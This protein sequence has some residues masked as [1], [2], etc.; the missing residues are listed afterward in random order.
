MMNNPSEPVIALVDDD[1]IFQLTASRM[2]RSTHLTHTILQFSNGE[3]ALR[4]LSENADKK[5]NLPDILFLDIN[6][7]YVD[8]WM[9]LEDYVKLKK[10]L[11]KE[12]L[13]YM[14]SSSIDP[15]DINRAKNN[16]SVKDYLIKPIS[17]EGFEELL[18]QFKNRSAN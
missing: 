8:G 5:E 1:T 4:Y 10:K 16:Q 7:P 13:I 3:E 17:R 18:Q 15:M 14:V 6:M 11:N 2:L 12:I 9:F